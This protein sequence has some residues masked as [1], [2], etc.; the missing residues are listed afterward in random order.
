[1]ANIYIDIRLSLFA[2]VYV[3]IKG[4]KRL[5]LTNCICL[6]AQRNVVRPYYWL[7]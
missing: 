2:L 3:L 1:M 4:T 6:I 7:N 5:A